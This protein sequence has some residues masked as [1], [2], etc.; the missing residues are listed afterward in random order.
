MVK[1]IFKKMDLQDNID[2][3]K[4][5]YYDDGEILNVHERTINL[6]P[7]LKDINKNCKK[8]DIDRLIEK[9]VTEEYTKNEDLLTKYVANYQKL[10]DK[11]NDKFLKILSKYLN[12]SLPNKDIVATV[13]FIPI[14]PRYLDKFSF[15][16]HD[17]IPDDFLIETCAHEICHFLW[18]K[19]WKKLYPNYN[20]DDFESPNKIWEYS[21]MIVDP[22][23]NSDECVSLFG[24]KT[25]YAY[26]YFYDQEGLMDN[27]FNIYSQEIPIEDKIKK[28][29]EY[30]RKRK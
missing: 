29:Y 15:S 30:I 10:W 12:V 19:K 28:G 13:G 4:M 22:I 7:R 25:R 1:V 24:K 9:V 21:E 16:V 3:V 27:L 2:L 23:L 6:F 17:S 26:D 5:S 20:I 11:Y 8:E 18:F 14:C